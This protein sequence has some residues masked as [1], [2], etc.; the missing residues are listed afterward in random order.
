MSKQTQATN[1]A[2]QQEIFHNMTPDM[3][4]IV[5]AVNWW[6]DLISKGINPE[7][8]DKMRDALEMVYKRY[9]VRLPLDVRLTV[10]EAL[11]AAKLGKL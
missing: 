10:E 5:T 1:V 3:L 7:S 4:A 9:D 6:Q 2:T 8:V 11:T